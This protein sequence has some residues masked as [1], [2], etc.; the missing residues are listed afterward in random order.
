MTDPEAG[1]REM[2]RVT[3]R[4]GTVAACVWDHAG[5]RGP[6]TVFWRA[7]R[8]LD[9]SAPDESGLAGVREGDLARLFAAAGL[10]LPPTAILTVRVRHPSFE[11]WWHPFTLGV[12]PAGAYLA[13]LEQQHRAEL[14]ARCRSLLPGEFVDV[15]ATAWAAVASI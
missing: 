10:G 12:G 8:E 1:L 9:P 15:D 14:C 4:G 6:L 11:Q 2:G 3:R 13:S 5:E 7:A